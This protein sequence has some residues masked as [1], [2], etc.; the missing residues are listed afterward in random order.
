[1]SASRLAGRLGRIRNMQQNASRT[2]EAESGGMVSPEQKP[3]SSLPGWMDHQGAYFER[4]IDLRVPEYRPHLSSLFPLLFPAEREILE[5]PTFI[6]GL[7]NKLVFFDLETTGLSH[8]SGTVAFMAALGFLRDN[9]ILSVHQLILTDYPG[10][11]LFLG[12]IAELTS[13]I[14]A[15]CSFNGKCFDSQILITRFLMNA[16]KPVLSGPALVHLDLLFPSRRIW[17][18]RFESCRLQVL[19]Q[20]V[21]SFFREDDLPG[22]EA[23]EAWFSFIERGETDRLLKIADHNRDDC[24]S[25]ARLFYRL[26]QAIERGEDRA[27]LIRAVELR[28][29]GRYAEAS[30]FLRALSEA[31]NPLAMRLLAIDL[32]HRLLDLGEAR[33]L[34]RRLGDEKR[35][36]R[37]ERKGRGR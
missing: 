6:S 8:G 11:T 3:P 13:G 10:E 2:A 12:R 29:N 27:A 25:L 28:R 26:D 15:A 9:D 32:E 30:V 22:S 16:M 33:E 18:D 34:A 1:M 14:Q 5:I 36:E 19:E 21:L 7:S 35:L 31:G 4:A 24:L 23:P 20:G 37:I 17:K